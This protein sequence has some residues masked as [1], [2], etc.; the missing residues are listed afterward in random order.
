MNRETE[1]TKKQIEA[2][3]NEIKTSYYKA[4]KMLILSL[5]DSL[6]F[7]FFD[8]LFQKH[9]ENAFHDS[10]LFDCFPLVNKRLKELL[11]ALRTHS[12]I[13]NPFYAHKSNKQTV[14]KWHLD[15]EFF[16]LRT[17]TK[18][19]RTREEL[20]SKAAVFPKNSVVCANQSCGQKGIV[21]ALLEVLQRTKTILCSVCSQPLVPVEQDNKCV[22]EL[23]RNKEALRK[24]DKEVAGLQSRLEELLALLVKKQTLENKATKLAYQ[25]ELDQIENLG[26]KGESVAVKLFKQQT[27]NSVASAGF[28]K[29]VP[30]EKQLPTFFVKSLGKEIAVEEINDALVDDMSENEYERFCAL[31][32]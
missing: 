5:G 7:V 3:Q 1:L 13:S 20:S 24:F 11:A 12:I 28:V 2:V 17:L 15:V 22:E 26:K 4:C 21:C 30:R 10:D 27:D 14:S 19:F 32:D 6:L 8:I 18:V 23:N 16:T 25:L 31:Y 29:V 9:Y